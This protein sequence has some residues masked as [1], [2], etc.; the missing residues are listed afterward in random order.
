MLINPLTFYF[1]CCVKTND[2]HPGMDFMIVFVKCHFAQIFYRNPSISSHDHM[3]SI[4]QVESSAATNNPDPNLQ[5]QH[6]QSKSHSSPLCL[7]Q[8]KIFLFL[9]CMK[10]FCMNGHIGGCHTHTCFYRTH[11]CLWSHFGGLSWLNFLSF[12]W[13]RTWGTE[14]RICCF[15]HLHF[16]AHRIMLVSE[17]CC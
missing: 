9:D 16:P 12:A 1:I 2:V 3:I 11:Y 14:S 15:L 13:S 8:G 4:F 7:G 17:L 5:Q 6:I 10:Y